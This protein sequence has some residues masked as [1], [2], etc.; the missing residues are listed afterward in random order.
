MRGNNISDFIAGDI[1][2]ADD[3]RDVDIFFKSAFFSW[4]QTVLT[5]VVAIIARVD[6]VGVVENAVVREPRNDITNDFVYGLQ[7]AETGSVE[8]I[9][10]VDIGLILAWER[11]DPI[12][13]ARLCRQLG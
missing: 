1:W 10:E 2:T 4:L 13:T 5:D 3:K 12:D 9:V 11:T 8:V 6:Y 7:C